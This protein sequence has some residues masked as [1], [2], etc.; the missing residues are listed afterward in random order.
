[1]KIDSIEEQLNKLVK[2]SDNTNNHLIIEKFQQELIEM[3][4][5]G[6]KF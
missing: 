1:L 2:Q 6:K 4:N 5:E 3:R